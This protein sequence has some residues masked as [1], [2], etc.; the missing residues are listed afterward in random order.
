MDDPKFESGEWSGHEMATE[1]AERI[2]SVIAA[3]EAAAGAVRH[4]AEQ[5]VA[6][7]R[8]AAEEEARRIVEDAKRDAEAMLEER[9]RRI[10]ELS[11]T[12]IERSD[13]LL[14]RLG[15]AEEVRRELQSLVDE[16]GQTAS[17][18][19]REASAEGQATPPAPAEPIAPA[20]V[21]EATESLAEPVPDREPHAAEP[22]APP[23]AGPG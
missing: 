19:A 10:S 5:Q 9:L 15:R 18:L 4:E 1:V 21:E 20:A 13:G 14:S 22:H 7:R 2:R 12:I 6:S 17:R 11:D 3:A 16:L 8:R 23:A